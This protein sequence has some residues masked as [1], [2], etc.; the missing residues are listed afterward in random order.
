MVDWYSVTI[1][2]LQNLWQGFLTFI[3]TLIGAIAVFIIGWLVSVG[4][5]KIVAG[6]LKKLNFNKLFEKEVWKQAMEKAEFKIDAAGFVGAVVKWIFVI[7]FLMA[8]V[9]ILGLDAFAGFLGGILDYLPNVVAA[10]FI[11]VAAVI[12]TDIVEKI[13]RVSVES[14]KV[15]YGHI[16]GVIVRWSILIFA[17]LAILL[18]L[19]VTPSLIQTMFTGLIALIV[20]AGGISFGLGGKEIA[21][22]VLK[23]L[24]RKLKG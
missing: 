11:F 19:Q 8:A 6:I 9:E 16:V 7:V 15:G 12:I 17:L 24:Y 13:V 5:G 21:N 20:I 18:Q 14:M 3:P 10:A 23:D 4:V 22:E 2:A 1:S